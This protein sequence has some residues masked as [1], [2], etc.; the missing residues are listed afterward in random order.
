MAKYL[1]ETGLSY[2][3]GKIGSTF[4]KL[5]GGTLTGKLVM[6]SGRIANTW[7]G[8]SFGRTTATPVE[9]ILYTGILW[10][11]SHHMPVIHITG[12]AYG[13]QSPVEFKIGFYIYG[14]K[15]GWAG[16]TNMGSWKPNVYL[17][18]YTNGDNEECVAVGLAGS[19]YFLQLQ[20]DLQD[21]MGKF[22]YVRTDSSKWSWT[23]STSTGVIPAL[24]TS[25]GTCIQVSYK[26]DILDS[27]VGAVKTSTNANHYLGFVDSSNS[28]TSLE[29]LY[30]DDDLK[31]NP[32]TN[33][34]TTG[35]VTA[36]KVTIDSASIGAAEHISFNRTSANYVIFPS[37]G[38]VNIATGCSLAAS[39]LSVNS[40]Y[41]SP[42]STNATIN[43]GT[44]SYYWGSVYGNAFV[45]KDSSDS[46][47]LLGGGGTATISS[48]NVASAQSVPA[49]TNSELDTICVL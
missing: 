45:K 1:D 15:I 19:C 35:A 31:Y 12:Y 2:L 41:V 33:T 14:G 11:S 18:K 29:T 16:V 28:S 46:Y 39:I 42:G 32:S 43:L 30:T 20:A 7:Y 17:F 13:L 4:L 5:S 6:P 25:G 44:S 27:R 34:L 47:V 10:S 38:S 23:F 36:K 49:I 3:W 8:I 48:L 37:N 9:T 26:A 40:T 24:D 21:E 22:Q